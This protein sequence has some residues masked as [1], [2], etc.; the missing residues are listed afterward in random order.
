MA[1]KRNVDVL[2][3]FYKFKFRR[4]TYKGSFPL[5]DEYEEG[6][7]DPYR[8]WCKTIKDEERGYE[9][10]VRVVE[11]DECPTA[12]WLNPET[13]DYEGDEIDE[14]EMELV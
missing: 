10:E 3:A 7:L 11:G 6:G 9:F 13:D 2:E 14:I 12:F 4:K 8:F 1:K 5:N